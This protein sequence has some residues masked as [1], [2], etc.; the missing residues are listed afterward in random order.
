M[1]DLEMQLQDALDL[2]AE[3]VQVSE[4]AWLRNEQLLR[5]S[6]RR[7]GRATWMILATAA[8]VVGVLI[9]VA[10]L[11]LPGGHDATPAGPTPAPSPTVSPSPTAVP[12]TP[13]P[14]PSVGRSPA[15][16]PG[17]SSVTTVHLAG[18]SLTLPTGW[19]AKAELPSGNSRPILRTWCLVPG[20]EHTTESSSTCAIAFSA[21]DT[22][23]S[24][25]ALSVDTEGGLQSNPEYCGPDGIAKE[26][27]DYLDSQFGTRPADYR[28]WDYTCKDGTSWS[29]EQYVADNAPGYVLFSDHA[30]AQVHGTMADIAKTAKL[31]AISAP[32]RLSDFG[33]VRSVEATTGGYH[34]LLD[35]VVQGYGKL[36]NNNPQT[37]PY[38][39]PAAALGPGQILQVGDRIALQTNGEVVTSLNAGP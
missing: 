3:R 6:P 12:S 38:D 10:V 25:E 37:Y 32:L 39:I 19:V 15:T 11:A 35:R 26:Q 20:P 7:R 13:P 21:V 31:P 2:T 1:N 22:G 17:V 27:L 4:H 28:H 8:C 30:T 18:A 9:A 33:I 23:N 16:T 29:I 24:T 36:I 14:T 5:E 34:I